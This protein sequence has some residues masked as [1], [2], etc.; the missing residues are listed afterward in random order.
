MFDETQDWRHSFFLTG[1][2]ARKEVY[3]TAESPE[4]QRLLIA[5][6]EREWKKWEEHKGTLP[7]TQGDLCMLKS[8]LPNLKV[9]GT[10]W[11]LT[12]KEAHFKARLVVQGCQEDPSMMRTD[13]PTSSRDSFSWFFPAQHK[14]IGAAVLQM[15]LLHICKQEG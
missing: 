4:N 14:N 9:V 8:R 13:S 2:A 7:L 3:F 12:P 15:L 1:R 6:M 10:R 5:A 11:V